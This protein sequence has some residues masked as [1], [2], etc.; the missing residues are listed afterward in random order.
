MPGEGR[1][2]TVFERL[3]PSDAAVE[4]SLLGVRDAIFWLEDVHAPMTFRA[5][6]T[7]HETDLAVV[8]GGYT[9][10]WSAVRA[11]QRDPGR[12]VVLLEARRLGW[13]A[14]GR[15]G[16]FCD[17]SV[18]HGEEN[19]RSRWPD[20]YDLLER[21][22]RENL[23]GIRR[24]VEEFAMDVDLEWTGELTVAVEEHQVDG[25]RE[26]ADSGAGRFLTADEVRAEVDSPTYLAGLHT[27]HTSLLHPAKL[28]DELARVATELGVEIYESSPVHSLSTDG[29][30]GPVKL[31]TDRAVVKAEQVVSATNAFPALLRRYRPFTVP[32]YDYVLVTEPLTDAQLAS[33]GWRNRQGLADSGN[34]FHYYRLTSGNRILFGGYDAIYPFGKKV[35]PEYEHRPESYRRL[36]EHFLTTFP[37]LEGVRFTH[38]WAGAIDTSTRFAAFYALA[39]QGRVAHT[40]GFTGLG[41]GATRFAADVVLDLLSGTETERTGLEMVRRL[42]V[43]FPPEPVA[44][45]GIHATRWSLDRADRNEGRRNLWLRALDKAGLGFDS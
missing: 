1:R 12:R 13:A 33:V 32:V 43:P 21:L 2:E 27:E 45:V 23:N 10:L 35:R 24:T 31:R 17:A 14:S 9:G 5:L 18:T 22:G 7:D 30:S 41:V 3:R 44:S 37:Q 8:G 11:K 28:V 6:T 19:G 42:P 25:L 36:A 16:G 26:A 40:A 29:R 4:E 15:N 34:Q 38:R 39:K 20:E